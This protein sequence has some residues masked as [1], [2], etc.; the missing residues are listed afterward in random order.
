MLVRVSEKLKL[1]E[2]NMIDAQTLKNSSIFSQ[3]LINYYSK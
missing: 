2:D 1:I 3:N